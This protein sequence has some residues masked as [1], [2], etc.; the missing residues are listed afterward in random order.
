MR[1]RAIKNGNVVWFG[2]CGVDENGKAK[3]YD[4]NKNSFSDK[5]QAVADSLSQRLH[6]I[7]TELWYNISFGLPLFEKTKS[8]TLIDSTVLNIVVAHPDVL[9]I[10]SFS[11][12]IVNHEYTCS[13]QVMTKYGIIDILI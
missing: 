11:S 4:E 8:K 1:C 5:Q 9:N 10:K 2:S 12:S 3:F 7:K 6:I 13:M